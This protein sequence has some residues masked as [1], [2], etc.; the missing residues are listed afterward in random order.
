MENRVIGTVMTVVVSVIL[1]GS[2]LAVSIS[3]YS[4][5]TR[6]YENDG[7]PFTLADAED[8][9]SHTLVLGKDADGKIK[10]TLDGEVCA[11]PDFSLYGS[12]S[13]LLGQKSFVRLA[14]GGGATLLGANGSAT[15]SNV[16]LGNCLD[17]D[18]T[19]T[20]TGATA[21]V[22]TYTIPEVLA[23]ISD[24]GDYRMTKNPMVNEDST[25]YAGALNSFGGSSVGI[26][27]YG[28][29]NDLT[30]K[31]VFPSG[32]TIGDV[33]V[34]LSNDVT[35]LYTLDNIQVECKD[36][37][38]NV[39]GTMTINFLLAPHVITYD[40]PQYMGAEF[41]GL[42]GAILVIAVAG[43]LITAVGMIRLRD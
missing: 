3:D 9:T 18:I 20:I 38:D 16:S 10:I 34:N 24:D 41:V 39:I 37:G 43:V 21:T 33:D 19:I 7:A 8:E 31:A 22:S 13:V 29:L 26:V 6:T 17:A 28:A 15:Y 2:L 12:A 1:I 27:L 32:R 4:E 30:T 25:V 14:S 11:N 36:S 42:L 35:N 5:A 40:N 23:Y